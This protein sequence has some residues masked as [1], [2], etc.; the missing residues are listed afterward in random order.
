MKSHQLKCSISVYC[1]IEQCKKKKKNANHVVFKI[2][3]MHCFL[4]IIPLLSLINDLAKTD[5]RYNG[6]EF[7]SHCLKYTPNL[8]IRTGNVRIS[9][10]SILLCHRQLKLDGNT[11]E[12]AYLRSSF[13]NEHHSPTRFSSVTTAHQSSKFFF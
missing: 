9:I 11:T 12:K 4:C 13:K 10:N 7:T 3:T 1:C 8:M 5:F 6:T 2:Y